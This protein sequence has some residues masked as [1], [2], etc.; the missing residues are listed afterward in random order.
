MNRSPGFSGPPKPRPVEGLTFS[1][2][3]PRHL[4]DRFWLPGSPTFAARRRVLSA[5]YRFSVR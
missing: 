2:A 4:P 5:P 3:L 1:A